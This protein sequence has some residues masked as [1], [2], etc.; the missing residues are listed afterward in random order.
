MYD[1][2]KKMMSDELKE[3]KLMN[4]NL[5]VRL[6]EIRSGLDTIIE[7]LAKKVKTNEQTIETSKANNGIGKY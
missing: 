6:A 3:L 1:L 4:Y 2:P 5:Q 7:L